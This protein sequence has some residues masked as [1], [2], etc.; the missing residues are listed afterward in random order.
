[1]IKLDQPGFKSFVVYVS[2]FIFLTLFIYLGI[3]YFFDYKNNKDALEIKILNDF[4]LHLNLTNKAKY[5]IFPSPRLNLKDVEILSFPNG[6]KNIGYANKVI[7]K[8]PFKQLVSLQKLN[9][10]S[11][12]LI[13]ADINIETS[14]IINF[15]NYLGKVK[16]KKPIQ[17]KNGKINLLDKTKL[18]FSINLKKLNISSKDLFD[19]VNLKG[20]IF[21][22]KIKINYQNKNL[23]DNPLTNV[24]IALPEIGLNFKLNA[25]VDQKNNENHYGRATIIF[26]NNQFYFDYKLNN[27]VISISS[28]KMINNYFKGQMLGDLLLFP[29]LSFELALNI[30]SLKFKNLLNSRLIKNNIL[31]Q[32]IPINN[33]INGKINI[34]I[35]EIASSSNIINSSSA[36]LQFKNGVLIVKVIKLNM[37]KIGE[38]SFNGKIL[39]QKKKKLFIFNNKIN[40]DDSNIFYS[41]FLIPEKHRVNIK[42]VNIHGK[43]NLESTKINLEKIY[44][45]N[46]IENQL[47]I[48]EL[49]I[50]NEKINEILSQNSLDNILKYSNFRKIIHSFF[51]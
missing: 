12:E 44:F 34:N 23:N 26:P 35:N 39:Q 29:F 49:T 42:P 8:I 17:F 10:Y 21:N 3:P 2:S 31:S 14:E 25:N 43:F 41:R 27:R 28:S 1:M 50:L 30:N 20:R 15:K 32:L 48:N 9:F 47:E 4:G 45:G 38:I 40:I 46:E 22:T 24:V 33:K 36:E 11:V 6:S 19:K 51:N 37:N 13:D 7:L 5:N 16:D 18:L